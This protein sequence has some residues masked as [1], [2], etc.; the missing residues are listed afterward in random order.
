MMKVAV[1][2]GA[3][4]NMALEAR[5]SVTGR[6]L[7][8][9]AFTGVFCLTSISCSRSSE[10]QGSTQPKTEPKAKSK[11]K[12]KDASPSADTAPPKGKPS[13]AQEGDEPSGAPGGAPAAASKKPKKADQTGETDPTDE[14]GKSEK[15]G[16]AP[17]GS[18]N[19]LLITLDTT[20]ADHLGC[21]GYLR[22]TSPA[23]DALARESIFFERCLVPIAQT[24]P[25]HTSILTGL[26][27]NEHGILANFAKAE[28]QFLPSENVISIAQVF[29]R[30]GY[31]TAGFVSA[32]PVK[33]SSG[34]AVGFE[35]WSENSGRSDRPAE[36]TIGDALDWLQKR[37]DRPFLMW[38]HLFDP[39][40][41]YEPKPPYDKMFEA[42]D[43]AFLAY[44][45]DHH[46]PDV[47]YCLHKDKKEEKRT[48]MKSS[49]SVNA[50]DAEIRY[51][52]DQ[53][54]VLFDKFQEPA[55]RDH[56]V[57]VLVGDHGES[58]G[59]HNAP[60]H[61]RIW[62]EQL[63]VPLMI[64]V[65]GQAPRRVSQTIS[66]VDIMPTV[67]GLTDKLPRGEFLLQATGTDALAAGFQPGPV[68]S[69]L[70]RES[71]PDG[72]AK[73][74]G[75]TI[76][77]D[78]WKY[79]V[80]QKGNHALYDLKKDPLELHNVLEDHAEVAGALRAHL[81]AILER[82][83]EKAQYFRP[84]VKDMSK[85]RKSDLEALGYVEGDPDEDDDEGYDD[86]YDE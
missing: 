53:L 72:S 24:L 49:E 22:D 71:R 10:S 84:R 30:N 18:M 27:P 56:T 1:D 58:L 68:L 82:Q 65:P 34:L 25:S 35:S 8:L 16:K 43:D 36:E 15:S 60:F 48:P 47:Y 44:L 29:S 21:Y 13:H 55:L 51:M 83:K 39:H 26:Y 64:R 2:E 80:D 78:D 69:Q 50:Y 76:T 57:I 54:K 14:T 67:L 73:D 46:F 41:P 70:P 85:S 3:G 23:I 33:R 79:M 62:I 59:Q 40:E 4:R 66:A 63:R 74:N 61:S 42:D 7:I 20:R 75:Y 12:A 6:L 5:L 9:G 32:T 17:P 19:L 81:S 77:T 86:G 45:A 31:H 11:T 28:Q 38:I 37:D 52:D